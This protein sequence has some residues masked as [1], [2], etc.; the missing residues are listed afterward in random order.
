LLLKEIEESLVFL[1]TNSSDESNES[2][3]IMHRFVE[4]LNES[5]FKF[6][7]IQILQHS[8]P[9]RHFKINI[10]NSE[11]REQW[12]DFKRNE[13]EKMVEIEFNRTVEIISSAW[14]SLPFNIF[15]Q[16][17][18]TNSESTFAVNDT[19]IDYVEEIKRSH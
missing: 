13:I 19:R 16:G 4:S 8:K 7:L 1:A 5:L 6:E 11:F 18:E 14:V 3:R 10:D 15:T 2:F 17:I 9:F 12:F